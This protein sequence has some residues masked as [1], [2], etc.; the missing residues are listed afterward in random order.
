MCICWLLIP[1]DWI[2]ASAF[3][4]NKKPNIQFYMLKWNLSSIDFA[5]H[6]FCF[7]CILDKKSVWNSKW[8]LVFMRSASF[9]LND[10]IW[11]WLGYINLWKTERLMLY[12][13]KLHIIFKNPKTTNQNIWINMH[14][15][16]FCILSWILQ[17]EQPN[18]YN[19]F[20]VNAQGKN[21]LFEKGTW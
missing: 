20:L 15:L 7:L 21:I 3:D 19:H 2:G 5:R 14:N 16:L 4:L 9:W 11:L 8:V 12:K 1:F 6:N 17:Q 10:A 13:T 18:Q